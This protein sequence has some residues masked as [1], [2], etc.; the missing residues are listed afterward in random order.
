MSKLL[1]QTQEFQKQIHPPQYIGL[2][3]HGLFWTN[4]LAYK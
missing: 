1:V 4:P 2:F 3:S